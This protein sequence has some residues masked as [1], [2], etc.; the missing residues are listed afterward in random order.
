MSPPTYRS[1]LNA[2]NNSRTLEDLFYVVSHMDDGAFPIWAVEY[3]SN[4]IAR[5][6]EQLSYQFSPELFTEHA[7]QQYDKK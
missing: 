5:K 6:A 3:L 4:A 2:V 1:L 7:F